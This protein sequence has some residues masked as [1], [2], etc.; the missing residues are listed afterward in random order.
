MRKMKEETSKREWESKDD[1]KTKGKT[2]IL[3]VA[4]TLAALLVI[5]SVGFAWA[6]TTGDSDVTI[7][8]SDDIKNNP[9]AMKILKNIELFK[10]NYA[11]LQQ[12]QQLLDQQQKFIEE[13]RRIANQYLQN[14]L[15]GMNN[16][17]NQNLPRNAYAAFVS[18]ID[19]STQN[20]FWDQFGF[21]ED[22]ISRANDAKNKVLKNGG[23]MEEAWQAYNDALAIHK[24]DL[25]SV[26]KQLNVKY[27]LADIKTQ[28]LFNKY[29]TLR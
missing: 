18:K 9:T 11:A 21:M 15:A 13:Q 10:K 24:T 22:K 29:G 19:N 3:I 1:K 27:H 16:L 12:R 5:S 7:K 26:N 6:E 23:S 4:S 20:L 28:N 14:D 17:N 25:V 2:Q 8:A